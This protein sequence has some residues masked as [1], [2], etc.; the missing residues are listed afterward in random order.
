[1]ANKVSETYA[2]GKLA[3]VLSS[4]SLRAYMECL[5]IHESTTGTA[6]RWDILILIA[7]GGL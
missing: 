6:A 1:M 4:W 5:Q 2:L 7:S 3:A